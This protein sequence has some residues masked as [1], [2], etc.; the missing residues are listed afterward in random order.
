MDWV[1]SWLILTILFTLLFM[2]GLHI[3]KE[4]FKRRK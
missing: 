2:V 3:V 4:F 1:F